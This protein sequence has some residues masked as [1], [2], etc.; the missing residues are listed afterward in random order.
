ME[1]DR[2]RIRALREESGEKRRE[3]AE[4]VRI[5]YDHLAAIENGHHNASIEVLHRIAS[6]LGVPIAEILPRRAA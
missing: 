6:R 1:A 4:S 3:F 5:S 2:T